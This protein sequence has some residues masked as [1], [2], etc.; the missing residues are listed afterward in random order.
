MLSLLWLTSWA[1]VA[2]PVRNCIDLRFSQLIYCLCCLVNHSGGTLWLVGFDFCFWMSMLNLWVND[3]CCKTCDWTKAQSEFKLGLMCCVTPVG[4]G[5]KHGVYIVALYANLLQASH[6]AFLLV[7]I[8]NMNYC[9]QWI[10]SYAKVWSN[11]FKSCFMRLGVRNVHVLIVAVTMMGP[12]QQESWLREKSWKNG[13]STW[14]TFKSTWKTRE[15]RENQCFVI[16]R[17]FV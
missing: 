5:W 8:C 11:Y 9:I 10:I 14:K 7:L 2:C 6:Y 1:S 16:S 15:K 12:C 4:L 17:F 13:K 3:I